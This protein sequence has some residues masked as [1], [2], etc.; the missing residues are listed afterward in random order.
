MLRSRY[1]PLSL[2]LAA[3]LIAGCAGS[4]E[5]IVEQSSH[6][7]AGAWDWSVDTPQGVFTGILT[8]AEAED[9]LSGT[10]AASDNPELTASLTE[11]M[12]D[13]A[14]SKVTFKYDSGEYGIMDVTLT[15]DGDAL[16]GLMNVTEFGVEVPM[17]CARKAMME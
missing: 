12:F 8:F 13:S 16:D 14:M 7:L 2:V 10:I 5:T 1:A 6:P 15:L 9:V 3:L 17:T 4:Q 11:L